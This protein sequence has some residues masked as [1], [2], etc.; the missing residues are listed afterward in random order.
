MTRNGDVGIARFNGV[1]IVCQKSID[2]NFPDEY[3]S[4]ESDPPP[5]M[6]QVTFNRGNLDQLIFGPDQHAAGARD[7]L[8]RLLDKQINAVDLACDLNDTEKEKLRLA[9]RGDIKHL[10]DR[11]AEIRARFENVAAIRDVAQFERW[12]TTLSAETDALRPALSRS[13]FVGNSLFAK[14][15]NR[16]LKPGQVAEYERSSKGPLAASINTGAGPSLADIIRAWERAAARRGRLDCTFTRFRYD[17]TFG[18]ERRGEGSLAV[19]RFGRAVYR[20]G[21]APIP[22]GAVA[23]K[24]APGG[25]P[26]QLQADD[27]ERWHWTG[28]R[29]IRV[30]EKER[31]FEEWRLPAESKD[32]EHQPD[33]PELP[34]DVLPPEAPAPVNGPAAQPKR[35]G[36]PADRPTISN[37]I[38][39]FLFVLI[40]G[41][42]IGEIDF[43]AIQESMQEFRLARPYLLGMRAD[44]LRQRFDVKLEKVEGTEVWLRFEP[45]RK[46]EQASLR[47][48]IL[49]LDIASYLPKALKEVDAAGAESVHVFNNMSV[50]VAH[51]GAPIP[52]PP[53][54]EP[55]D[56]PNLAG[57]SKAGH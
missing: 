57:Y 13:L 30:D 22:R 9:G 42:M 20:I 50:M 47:H 28:T 32:G 4:L 43:G 14:T 52:V 17:P 44:E 5:R 24:Q 12:A 38:A 34:E 15:L 49:I 8:V 23:R 16:I 7:R 53:G 29:V 3:A 54:K 21:P 31:T 25:V 33:P 41:P 40:G 11:A 46:K 6:M 26:F 56:R 51:E 18:V 2:P 27:P 36:S 45:K 39:G 35:T 48:A 10:L 37:Q 19:D 55:L 1:T